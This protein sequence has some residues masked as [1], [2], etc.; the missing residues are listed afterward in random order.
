MALPVTLWVGTQRKAFF[1]GMKVNQP[2]IFL[3][4]L[5]PTLVAASV[6]SLPVSFS[7]NVMKLPFFSLS[8]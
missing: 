6:E 8:P 3:L 5:I 7:C 4:M 1:P 2:A